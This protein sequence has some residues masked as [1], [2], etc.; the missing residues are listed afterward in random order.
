MRFC[1][2]PGR[3]LVVSLNSCRRN[4]H[5]STCVQRSFLERIYSNGAWP[6]RIVT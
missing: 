3:G 2:A 5:L 6:V 4:A 1:R